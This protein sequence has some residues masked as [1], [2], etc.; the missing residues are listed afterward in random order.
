MTPLLRVSVD[1]LLCLW[2]R[3]AGDVPVTGRWT[4]GT[5]TQSAMHPQSDLNRSVMAPYLNATRLHEL[6]SFRSIDLQWELWNFPRRQVSA[7]LNQLLSR[8]F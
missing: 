7:C 5:G 1:R 4:T 6:Q 8:I 3:N 2:G